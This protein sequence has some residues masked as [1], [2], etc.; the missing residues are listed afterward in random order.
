M[1]YSQVLLFSHAAEYD[2]LQ[3]VWMALEVATN[4]HKG[5]PADR[6]KLWSMLERLLRK[7]K[8]EAGAETQGIR[9]KDLAALGPFEYT[10][11]DRDKWEE[12]QRKRQEA[13]ERMADLVARRKTG[14]GSK[15]P[16][17]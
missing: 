2:R 15:H 9:V 6:R 14:G 3:A 13:R 10:E 5:K 8:V 7:L 4:P 1:S 11:M 12:K 16:G 17:G